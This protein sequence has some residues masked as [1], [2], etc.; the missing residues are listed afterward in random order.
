M[1]YTSSGEGVSQPFVRVLVDSV[2][3]GYVLR[4]PTLYVKAEPSPRNATHAASP[5][6]NL[7]VLCRWIGQPAPVPNARP[8][9][10]RISPPP[11]PPRSLARRG[12]CIL[13][14]LN[15]SIQA[16]WPPAPCAVLGPLDVANLSERCEVASHVAARDSAVPTAPLPVACT[17]ITVDGT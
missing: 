9:D 7:D 14:M 6:L 2:K 4:K 1:M 16:G 5:Y 15:V 17:T 3:R 13:S 11:P 10:I 12:S 8:Y